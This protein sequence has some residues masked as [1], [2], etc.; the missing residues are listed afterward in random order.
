[1][2]SEADIK[3]L[4]VQRRRIEHD[5]WCEGCSVGHDPGQSY[6]MKWIEKYAG[7]YRSAWNNSLCKG[8]TNYKECG[9]LVLKKCDRYDDYTR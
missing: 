4:H 2:C 9:L 5:K 7:L 6:V 3:F 8:C 1:M